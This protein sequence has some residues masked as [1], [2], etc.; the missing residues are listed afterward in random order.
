LIRT[1]GRLRL[2]PALNLGERVNAFAALLG[3]DLLNGCNPTLL[4]TPR[5]SALPTSVL[6]CPA[7]MIQLKAKSFAATIV[8]R[9]AISSASLLKTRSA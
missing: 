7:M 3:L 1:G 4:Q 8:N 6:L 5:D 9:G 2:E